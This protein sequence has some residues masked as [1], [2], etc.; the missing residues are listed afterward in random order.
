MTDEQPQSQPQPP[1][2]HARWAFDVN[3]GDAHRAHDG[4][5]EFH[6]Y[7]NKAAM[8]GANLALRTLIIINGGAAVAV[9]T[10]L[11][12]VASKTQIDF[13][14]VGVVAGTLQWFAWGVALGVLA[15]V[16]AYF[17]NYSMAAIAGKR[18]LHYEHPFVRDTGASAFWVKLNL[19]FH[20]IAIAAALGSLLS[21][22]LGMFATS[23]AVTHLLAS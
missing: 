19:L 17:T 3:R 4:N 2:D 9:L 13:A 16:L 15:M 5:A 23:H 10:F 22:M 14:K 8:D 6:T 1:Y 21:F 20:A 18:S 7:V 11:G 12:G